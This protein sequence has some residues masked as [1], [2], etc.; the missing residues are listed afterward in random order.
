MIVYKPLMVLH[1]A[2]VLL[3]GYGVARYLLRRETKLP[4]L[5]APLVTMGIFFAV[6]WLFREV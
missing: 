6:A 2:A 4:L 5:V 3:Y 1:I